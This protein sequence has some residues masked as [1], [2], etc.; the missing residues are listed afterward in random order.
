MDEKTPR[1]TAQEAQALVQDLRLDGTHR[2]DG[3]NGHDYCSIIPSIT[4]P[5]YFYVLVIPGPEMQEMRYTKRGVIAHGVGLA[6]VAY[7]IDPTV[8]L[9]WAQRP[10]PQEEFSQV[11]QRDDWPFPDDAPP[12][13]QLPLF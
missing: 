12:R 4:H 5:G 13:G 3:T 7:G 6:L 2:Y 9:R 11:L 10:P 1:P 8:P